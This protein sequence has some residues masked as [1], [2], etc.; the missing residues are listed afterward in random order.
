MSIRF[1][2]AVEGNGTAALKED[3]MIIILQMVMQPLPIFAKK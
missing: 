2:I 1:L 3:Y